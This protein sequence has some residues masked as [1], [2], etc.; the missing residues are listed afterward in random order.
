VK[1]NWNTSFGICRFEDVQGDLSSEH[2]DSTLKVTWFDAASDD[3]SFHPVCIT[4]KR[5]KWTKR[6]EN[7]EHQPWI[8]TISRSSVLV[9][10][11]V[12]CKLHKLTPESMLLVRKS[13]SQVTN[14]RAHIFQRREEQ[15]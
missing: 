15:E 4:K 10:G 7:N 2:P 9:A 8:A 13:I 1:D 3:A 5:H 6:C 11:V 12:L 14:K